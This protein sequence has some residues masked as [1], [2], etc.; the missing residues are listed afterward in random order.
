MLEFYDGLFADS[1]AALAAA[2]SSGSDTIITIDANTTITLQN[3]LL[4]NLHEDDFRLV[5]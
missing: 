2:S 5:A 1:A 3:V 4:S